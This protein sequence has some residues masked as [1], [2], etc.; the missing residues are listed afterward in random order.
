MNKLNLLPQQSQDIIKVFEYMQFCDPD[1]CHDEAIESINFL[2]HDELGEILTNNLITMENWVL[3][4]L[5]KDDLDIIDK[6]NNLL[7]ELT[8]F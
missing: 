2:T 1:G 5:N 7:D 6:I 8:R 3:D 4:G